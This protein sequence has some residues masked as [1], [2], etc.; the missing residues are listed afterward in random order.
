MGQPHGQELLRVRNVVRV[1]NLRGGRPSYRIPRGATYHA[2]R[3]KG[4]PHAIVNEAQ[5]QKICDTIMASPPGTVVVHCEHGLNRTGLVWVRCVMR[6]MRGMTARR[7]MRWFRQRRPPGIQRPWITEHLLTLSKRSDWN[8]RVNRTPALTIHLPPR[9]R[10]HPREKQPRDRQKKQHEL[11]QSH[12]SK[13]CGP[14]S[15]R[16][17][18]GDRGDDEGTA[19]V[20]A[21]TVACR[22]GTRSEVRSDDRGVVEPTARKSEPF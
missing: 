8:S 5:I 19:A 12:T 2:F 10:R 15:V 21:T 3:V 9:Q 7:V 17:A 4:G 18:G 11:N 1:V 20:E 14:G 22:H 13:T 16:Q 6:E